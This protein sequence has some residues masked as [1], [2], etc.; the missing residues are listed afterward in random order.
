M[1]RFADKKDEI[2]K[3]SSSSNR[4]TFNTQDFNELG[5]ALLNEP[6][7]VSTI[8]VTKNGEYAEEDT[9]PIK[10]LRKG[11]IGGVLKA[12]GHDTAEQEKFVDE[13]QFPVLP[14]YPY[15]SEVIEQNLRCGKAL[16]LRPKADLRATITMESKDE[17]IKET[18]VPATGD[19]RKTKMGAYK[20]VK[21][22]STCP[23]NLREKL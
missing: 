22:K 2:M 15:I 11:L 10:D 19:V 9:T 3:A 8:V 4:K 16:T 18:K 23:A 7:Y 14:L 13:Y 17:E 20:K 5:T 21:V 1:G 6:D 12:A